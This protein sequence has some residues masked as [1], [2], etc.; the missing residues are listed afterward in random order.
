VVPGKSGV[1][2]ENNLQLFLDNS[3]TMDGQTTVLGK[4]VEGWQALKDA[5]EIAG[6]TAE[7]KV[8]SARLLE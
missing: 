1:Q 5:V 7:F 3:Y 4:V 6:D 2:D 8:L